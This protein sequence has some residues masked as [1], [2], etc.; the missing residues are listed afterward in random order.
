MTA[1]AAHVLF[2][3]EVFRRASTVGL[4]AAAA[5]LA[6]AD[7]PVFPC[8]PRGKCP[9]TRHGF[10]DATTQIR[11]VRRWWSQW[12]EA[13]IGLRTGCGIDVLDVDRHG[14][15]SGF[16]TLARLR[17]AGLTQGWI[18]AIRS[19]SGGL[20]LYYPSPAKQQRSWSRPGAQ[21][22]FRA[23][24]GYIIAPPSFGTRPDSSLAPY[25]LIA[26]HTAGRPVDAETIR[27][28]LTPPPTRRPATGDTSRNPTASVDRLVGWVANLREGS[29]NTGLF[30]AACRAA[31]LDLGAYD[32]LVDAAVTAGLN[33]CEAEATATS[34]YRMIAQSVDTIASDAKAR[35]SFPVRQGLRR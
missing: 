27:Q 5:L 16:G 24:G 21:L 33:P 30:W 32:M 2:D 29:R 25:R 28:L 6:A 10:H 11:R 3:F 18:A 7:L 34:A 26:A 31:E 14:D 12:P 15:R 1:T 4:G 20:H 22:D 17:R 13:N 8:A 23:D 35:R 9:L 19:P